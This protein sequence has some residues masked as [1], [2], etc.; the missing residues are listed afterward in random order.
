MPLAARLTDETTH[1]FPL[2]PGPGS[3]NV[4]IGSLPA[5]RT[6][7]DVHAC[8]AVSI[9]GPDGPGT[10]LVG[11]PTVTINNMMA[12][13]V[14][15]IVVEVPGLA[16]GPMD[17][18]LMGCP[19]V[20]I[21]GPTVPGATLALVLQILQTGGSADATDMGL[22]AQQ[23]VNLPPGMLQTM[24][25]Q[26]QHVVICRGAVTDYRTDYLG[27]QP[28]GWPAGATF[29]QVT[30]SYFPDR[31]E[32]V[33][34]VIGH[35]TPAGAHVP[36][37][38]EGQGSSNVV[39]HEATHAVDFA[40]G[41]D[42]SATDRNFIAARNADLATLSPYETQPGT[43]GPEES[44]AESSARYHSGDPTD[45]TSHPNLNKYWAGNPVGNP[46]PTGGSGSP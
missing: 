26:N 33:I 16:L 18:I 32:V 17:P 14:M 7:I 2:F 34:A 12:C 46:A 30:G 24:I 41:G 38:G 4:L 45:A 42:R 19:T 25:N 43:A 9:S 10:V 22:A 28:R 39:L 21:G 13:R 44:Y 23:L 20:E 29:N 11:S 1:G 35:G 3:L 5:W 36:R 27:V 40:P 8:Y 15:D 31:K 37:A 6:L